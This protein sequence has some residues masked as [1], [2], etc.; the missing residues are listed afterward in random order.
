[1]LHAIV[2]L[3]DFQTWDGN[4]CDIVKLTYNFFSVILIPNHIL[5]QFHGYNSF[6]CNILAYDWWGV[7]EDEWCF[8]QYCQIEALSFLLFFFI[9]P[10][11][12]VLIMSVLLQGRKIWS[13]NIKNQEG[14]WAEINGIKTGL[15]G[16]CPNRGKFGKISIGD[17]IHPGRNNS[18]STQGWVERAVI[19]N[20]KFETER[21]ASGYERQLVTV[22]RIQ[23]NDSTSNACNRK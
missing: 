19:W 23:L 10:D 13:A 1:M 22:E 18:E 8:Q 3:A 15:S 16:A 5:S 4:W 21:V 12:S 20:K 9:L 14:E 11:I 7:D 6:Q 17:K 2:A